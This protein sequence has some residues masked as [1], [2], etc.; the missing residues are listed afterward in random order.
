MIFNSLRIGTL[1]FTKDLI[2]FGLSRHPELVPT[3]SNNFIVNER[4]LK[5]FLKDILP[6]YLKENGFNIII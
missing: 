4:K 1:D 3:S 5:S 6:V 2:D